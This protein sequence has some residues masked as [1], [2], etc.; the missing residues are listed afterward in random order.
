MIENFVERHRL[1]KWCPAPDCSN[2]VQMKCVAPQL[3]KCNCGHSF[4]F[5]CSENWHAPIHC[6]L[7]KHWNKI[8]QK[9]PTTSWDLL[10]IKSCPGCNVPIMKNGGCNFMECKMCRVRFCWIC[11]KTG[12]P[13]DYKDHRCN[14][15]V[16]DAQAWA[17][18][19]T[20]SLA[21]K[22]YAFHFHRC[23]NHLQARDPCPAYTS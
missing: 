6:D 22:R 19:P 10:N 1:M 17:P 5:A 7:I 20:N 4:C 8:I 18:A 2:A 11:M 16:I 13:Y 21:L 15:Y 12:I 3:V 14:K 9:H 23:M